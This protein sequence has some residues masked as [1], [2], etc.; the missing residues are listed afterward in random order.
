LLLNG[1]QWCSSA[2]SVNSMSISVCSAV[3]LTAR[4]QRAAAILSPEGGR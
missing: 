4:P 1:S 2:S 3:Y